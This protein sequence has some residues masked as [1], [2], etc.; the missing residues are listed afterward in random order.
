MVRLEEQLKQTSR[1][2]SQTSRERSQTSRERSQTSRAL[3]DEQSNTVACG[4]QFKSPIFS[5]TIAKMQG[6]IFA[7]H[8]SRNT[9]ISKQGTAVRLSQSKTSSIIIIKNNNN[10]NKVKTRHQQ[11][12]VRHPGQFPSSRRPVYASNELNKFPRA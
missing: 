7:T 5:H 9:N 10:N 11:Y 1:E 6:G 12:F 2:R 8:A 4:V 3:P